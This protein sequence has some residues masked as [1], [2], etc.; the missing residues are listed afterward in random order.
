MLADQRLQVGREASAHLETGGDRRGHLPPDLV[1][2]PEED[3]ALV[4][5]LARRRLA[6]VVQQH[7]PRYRH[8]RRG[9][10]QT[11]LLR[12]RQ[13]ARTA[14]LLHDPAHVSQRLQ[15]VLEHVQMVVGILLDAPQ[16]VQLGKYHRQ[17]IPHGQVTKRQGGAAG[18]ERCAKLLAQALAADRAQAG[19][20]AKR[21]VG[22]RRVGHQVETARQSSQADHAQGIV[23]QGRRR[24]QTQTMGGE[25]VEAAQRID[26]LVALQRPRQR[27]DGEV[28]SAQ[29]GLEPVAA[30][31]RHVHLEPADHD[32]P[33]AEILGRGKD[34]AAEP[35]GQGTR[36]RLGGGADDDV[37]VAHGD[38]EQLIAQAAADKPALLPR[39]LQAGAH[40]RLRPRARRRGSGAPPAGSRRTR[41]RN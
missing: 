1:V 17:S 23:V 24:A 8:E 4:V 37:H 22:G 26:E 19:G 39:A 12:R 32:A 2:M 33:G 29:I 10:G 7:R 13:M 38:A 34:G 28:T 14:E 30:Q 6:D 21:R 20:G 18:R 27:V 15:G 41:P 5:D 35:V 9:A 3:A 25:V 11:R 16:P 36:E 31:R 40:R